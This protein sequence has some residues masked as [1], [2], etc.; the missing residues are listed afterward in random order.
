M[1][2]KKPLS[3]HE[4]FINAVLSAWEQWVDQNDKEMEIN[5]HSI[6]VHRGIIQYVA[7]GNQAKLFCL[8]WL[9]YKTSGA[10][11][12]KCNLGWGSKKR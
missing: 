1:L 7:E 12:V 5:C 6:W 9:L 10:W 11:H 8:A 2:S 4:I 3:C